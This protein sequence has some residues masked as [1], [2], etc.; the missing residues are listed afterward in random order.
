MVATGGRQALSLM[1]VTVLL[2][3]CADGVNPSGSGDKSNLKSASASLAAAKPALTVSVDSLSFQGQE[4]RA[5]PPSQLLTAQI[6]GDSTKPP[7]M[8]VEW[9]GNGLSSVMYDRSGDSLTIRVMPKDPAE[10]GVGTFTDQ[11]VVFACADT[12][13]RKHLDGSPKTVSVTYTVRNRLAVAP[14]ALS[15]AHV[16]GST[17]FPSPRA[18][19]LQGTSVNWAASADSSWIR[20]SATSGTT[21][22]SLGIGIEPTALPAGG[23]VGSVT[24]TNIDSGESVV[25]P[26][27][28]EIGAPVLSAAPSALNFSGMEGRYM[29]GQAL[30][31]SL[32]TGDSAYAWTA[33]VN[34]QGGQEWLVLSDTSGTVSSSATALVIGVNT[35]GLSGGN[36]SGSVTISTEVEGEPLSRTIPVSLSLAS[37]QWVADNGVALVS[38]PS[39]SKLNHTVTV[40]NRWGTSNTAW[41]AS[42]DQPWLSVTASGTSGGSLTMTA[43]PSGLEPNTIHY[44]RVNVSYGNAQAQGNEMIR[45]GLWVGNTATSSQNSIASTFRVIEADPVRPYAYVHNNGGTLHVYNVYTASLVTSIPGVGSSLGAMTISNDGSTLYVLDTS[46]PRR[47]IPVDLSTFTAGTPWALN[48]GSNTLTSVITYARP[49]GQAVVLTNGGK[50]F[51][52][53]TG[54]LIPNVMGSFLTYVSSYSASLDGSLFCGVYNYYYSDYP[55]YCYGMQYTELGGGSITLNAR[56]NTSNYAYGGTDVAINHDG[57]R[58]YLAYSWGFNV[59]DGLTMDT[60]T[61]LYGDTSNGV[62]VGAD[63]RFYGTSGYWYGSRDLWAYDSSNTLLNS[64]RLAGYGRAILERQLKVSG[65]GKRIMVLT[66]DPTLKFITTP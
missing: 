14:A 58:V 45:V 50:V 59:H 42:S 44:A 43:N 26:V 28:L 64:Y 13:C 9:T 37:P 61:T 1:L 8:D 29:P 35:Q 20:L 15:F 48:D 65:D 17:P 39:I 52:A 34:T 51:N 24:L 5:A 55:L 53:S 23:H 16:L 27:A 41:T 12:T 60:I 7:Y 40:K 2:S 4:G 31:L 10:V 38:T 6:T 63:D 32:N 54:A 18:L 11:V 47:I 46:A 57:S 36:Y 3:A 21:P 25:V 30:M 56:P 19:S 66:D 22:S 49:N 62:E 33:T